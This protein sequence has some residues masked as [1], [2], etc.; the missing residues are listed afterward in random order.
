MFGGDDLFTDQPTNLTWALTLAGS[1]YWTLLEPEGD[2]PP[3]LVH[4]SAIYD[5]PRDALA[6]LGGE[7]REMSMNRRTSLCCGGGGGRVFMTEKRGSKINHMRL[8]QA[9]Q[10]GAGVVASACPFCLTMFRD[11]I[12]A[13]SAGDQLQVQDLAQFLAESVDGTASTS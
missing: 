10:T 5:A 7:M 9:M 6:S 3:G 13:K 11:G 1:P 12:A 8:D 4:H 2:L